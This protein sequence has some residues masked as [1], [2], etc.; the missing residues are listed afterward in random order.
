MDSIRNQID[1]NNLDAV[2]KQIRKAKATV[3]RACTAVTKLQERPFTHTTH[4]ASDEARKCLQ[5]AYDLC[6]DLHNRW[7]DLDPDEEEAKVRAAESMQPYEEKYYDSLKELEAFLA[8]NTS[9]RAA[10]MAPPPQDDTTSA[11][12][13]LQPC[14]LLF[15]K[16]LTKANTPIEFRMWSAA[17]LRWHD[18][19]GLGKQPPA[20]QQAYFLQALDE[21]LREIVERQLQTAM[22]IYGPAGCQSLIEAEFLS[23]YPLFNR[24]VEF[25]Q[26]TRSQG[27]DTGEFLRR[28]SQLGD[29]ADLEAMSK[30]ELT[31]F[32]FIAACSDTRLRDKIFDLPRKDITT[33]KEAVNKYERQK[34]AEAALGEAPALAVDMP[35]TEGKKS[36]TAK[37]C[38]NCGDGGHSR[39]DCPI[40]KRGVLCNNCGR[41]AT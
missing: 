20:Q 19:S 11:A 10:A 39:K 1:W 41:P 18:A 34:K 21:E 17:F 29:M 14:K 15:P 26:T 8:A 6:L 7:E 2:C 37:S 31:V 22:P 35:K 5:E 30:E 32:R 36:S 12:P 38:F 23:L 16:P 24:R 25:F 28:L 40:R 13:I 4:A 3:T 9:Q 33:V 27:E